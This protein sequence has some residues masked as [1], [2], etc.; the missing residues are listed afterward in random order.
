M[1]SQLPLTKVMG[2][3]LETISKSN[4]V[5]KNK[6]NRITIINTPDYKVLKTSKP[7]YR[8]PTHLNR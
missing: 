4:V 8:I 2:F 7:L 1:F 5:I 3:L 6:I